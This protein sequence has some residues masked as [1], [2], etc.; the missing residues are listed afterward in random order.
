MPDKISINKL[1]DLLLG[2]D[3]ILI[4]THER[5]DG[6]AIGSVVSLL[7]LF[8][9]LNKTA[10]AYFPEP[11]PKQYSQYLC[12]NIF[13]GNNFPSSFNFSYCIGLDCSNIERLAVIKEKKEEILSL[14]IINIDHHY[15]NGLFGTYNYIDPSASS[16]SEIIFDIT[17]ISKQW[18]MSSDIATTII[19]GILMDTGGFR[20]DNTSPNVLKKTA[21]L[22][23]LGGNYI[24]TVKAMYFKKPYNLYKFEAD[25]AIKHLK[26][27]FNNR[28]AYFY[29]SNKAL[30]QYNLSKSDTEGLI[31]SIRIINGVDVAAILTQKD[32]GFKISLRS[33]NVEFPVSDIAHK[34]HGGGH[35]LAAGCF[36]N[37]NSI[38][39]AEQVLLEHVK[40]LL[41]A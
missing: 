9:K 39:K 29:M 24:D 37:E 5:P 4:F 41:H 15:D 33:N 16:T 34:L 1:S 40:N 10:N 12:N 2:L 36:I 8:T 38:E 11:I 23:K 14:P 18:I 22:M 26:M 13:I 20:F 35:K 31:D 27:K 3:D 7:K 28:F 17:S 32:N 21:S 19:M 30:E 6:D 25:I